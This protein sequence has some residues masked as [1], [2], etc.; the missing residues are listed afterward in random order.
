MGDPRCGPVGWQAQGEQLLPSY[1]CP[2]Q[3]Q[4]HGGPLDPE[5]SRGSWRSGTPAAAPGPLSV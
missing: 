3:C 1:H 4:P 5:A 2:Q